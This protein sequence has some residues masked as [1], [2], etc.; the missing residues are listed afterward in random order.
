M[1]NADNLNAIEKS[2]IRLNQ[3]IVNDPHDREGAYV[4]PYSQS[5]IYL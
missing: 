1:N 4:S 2:V 5:G 3:R